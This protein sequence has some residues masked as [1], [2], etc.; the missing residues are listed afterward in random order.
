MRKILL[1][2][3]ILCLTICAM[4]QLDAQIADASIRPLKKTTKIYP[5][6]AFNFIGLN[7]VANVQSITIYNLVGRKIKQFQTSKDKRYD[8]TDLPRG[9]YLVQLVGRDGKVVT[10]Q[11]MSKK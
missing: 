8:I 4:A 6:P 5:N 7:N 3:P 9:M 11:R 1:I 10:T 2:I